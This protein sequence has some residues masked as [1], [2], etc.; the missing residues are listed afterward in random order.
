MK[1]EIKATDKI[2]HIDGVPVRLWE[3]KTEAGINCYVFVHRIAVHKNE[4][5]EEFDK[6][7]KEQLPPGQVIPL[8]NIL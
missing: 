5:A 4:N 6:S 8:R 1:I 3:G 7:L 2:T